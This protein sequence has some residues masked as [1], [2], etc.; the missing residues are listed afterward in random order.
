MQTSVGNWVFP[1]IRSKASAAGTV[2]WYRTASLLMIKTDA[3]S[4]ESPSRSR[5]KRKGGYSA[6][7]PAE[8]NGGRNTPTGLTAK[9]STHLP[10]R[11]A[12]GHSQPTEIR[13]ASIAPTAVMS[14]TDSEEVPQ[15]SDKQFR[16]EKLY[17]ISVSIAKSMLKKG[18]IDREV[19]AIID[20]KLLEKYRPI[21]AT[22]LSGKPLI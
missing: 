13:T 19:Y 7:K 1:R 5:R 10:V 14:Q 6:V 22:L 20:T 18:I 11:D 9:L 15:M 4:A 12:G 2:L 21:S 8:R 17:Y 16:A 3:V